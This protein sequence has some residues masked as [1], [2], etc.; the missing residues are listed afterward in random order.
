MQIFADPSHLILLSFIYSNDFF[1]VKLIIQLFQ[2]H[3]HLKLHFKW[4]LHSFNHILYHFPEASHPFIHFFLLD[5]H[6]LV[7][8]NIFCTTL[9]KLSYWL[10]S[11]AKFM[12]L[13]LS[14]V[15]IDQKFYKSTTWKKNFQSFNI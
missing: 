8:L 6:K 2:A 1:A 15:C 4:C 11:S 12:I 9:R 13:K 10:P 14:W 5:G 3:K 7:T